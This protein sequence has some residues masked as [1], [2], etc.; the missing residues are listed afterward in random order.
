MLRKFVG[1][2]FRSPSLTVQILLIKVVLQ[3]L[4]S[5]VYYDWFTYQIAD[6]SA[7]WN[8]FCISETHSENI[9]DLIPKH[10]GFSLFI[11]SCSLD[12][13]GS[14][15]LTSWLSSAP[16]SVQI[17]QD[18]SVFAANVRES[19][20]NRSFLTAQYAR[21]DAQKD[22]Y[23]SEIHSWS[24]VRECIIMH[25]DWKSVFFF[26][27]FFVVL[28]VAMKSSEKCCLIVVLWQIVSGMLLVEFRDSENVIQQNPQ[29]SQ[30]IQI[31]LYRPCVTLTWKF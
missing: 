8:F 3:K 31:H 12:F 29:F 6:H 11:D 19:S 2:G 26:F 15:T 10:C 5:M 14:R 23:L 24:S 13:Q 16:V 9:V 30:V 18:D 28:G 1:L 7:I 4:N 21:N 27:P 22:T 20:G 25:P 17:G